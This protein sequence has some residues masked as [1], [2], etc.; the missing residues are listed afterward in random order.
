MTV[1]L[2]LFDYKNKGVVNKAIMPHISLHVPLRLGLR[3]R[4]LT[5]FWGKFALQP[6]NL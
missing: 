4:W 6:H 2:W 3:P 5:P 1:V